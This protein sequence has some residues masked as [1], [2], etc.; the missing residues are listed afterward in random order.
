MAISGFIVVRNVVSQGY[1]F[2]EAIAAALPICDEFLISDG[3]STDETWEALQ[4]LEAF[5]PGKIRLFQDEW[6]GSTCDSSKL[7]PHEPR[8]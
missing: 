1:P 3:C 6:K 5:Y 2:I 8:L 4:V 7:G